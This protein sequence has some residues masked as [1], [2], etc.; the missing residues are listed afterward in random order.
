MLLVQQQSWP[1]HEALLLGLEA[2]VLAG[3]DRGLGLTSGPAPRVSRGMAYSPTFVEL[4]PAA[5]GG[6]AD[7]RG[8][9]VTHSLR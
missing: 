1:S 6:R 7:A 8:V 4:G 9:K 5:A 3:S 2:A